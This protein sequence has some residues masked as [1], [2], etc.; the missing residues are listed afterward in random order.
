MADVYLAKMRLTLEIVDNLH[1][2][3]A[4]LEFAKWWNDASEFVWSNIFFIASGD[5]DCASQLGSYFVANLPKVLAKP[6]PGTWQLLDPYQATGWR[7]GAG[8]LHGVYA[9]VNYKASG[10][11]SP[12]DIS[13]TYQ[14]QNYP[15]NVYVYAEW[16]VKT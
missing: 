4:R 5:A 7:V 10:S 15:G 9:R 3:A 6:L 12:W 11:I 16:S 2:D 8:G 13:Y 1:V 14:G